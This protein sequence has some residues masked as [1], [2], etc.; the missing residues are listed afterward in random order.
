MAAG[1][2]GHYIDFPHTTHTCA[3]FGY[4]VIFFYNIMQLVLVARIYIYIYILEYIC[5]AINTHHRLKHR[6]N[7][8]YIL[9]FIHVI[10][11]FIRKSIRKE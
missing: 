2:K 9:Y 1:L 10:Y 6:L 11:F 8:Q 5:L 3:F 4:P 7:K